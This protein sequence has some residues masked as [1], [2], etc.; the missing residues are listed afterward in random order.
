MS[1]VAFLAVGLGFCLII[2]GLA[3]AL[4]PRQLRT[5]W[6]IVGSQPPETIRISGI[7]ALAIG[8]GIVWAVMG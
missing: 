5:L 2:E 7:V 6:E 1:F 4:F 8:V 3:Y